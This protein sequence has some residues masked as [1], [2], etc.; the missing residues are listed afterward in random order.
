MAAVFSNEDGLLQG[1][2]GVLAD[3]SSD[4][5]EAIF[6]NWVARLDARIQRGRVC[7]RIE[8]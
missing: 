8:I 1:V 6:A 5:L 7:R 2:I 3:I 4:E